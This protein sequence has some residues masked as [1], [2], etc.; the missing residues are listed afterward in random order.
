MIPSRDPLLLA[1]L[2]PSGGLRGAPDADDAIARLPRDANAKT[3][4]GVT[5]L[6]A[7]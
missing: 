1:P 3:A 4:A 7:S 2:R 5:A 6:P